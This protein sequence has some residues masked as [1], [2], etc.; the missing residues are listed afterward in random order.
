MMYWLYRTLKWSS[1]IFPLKVNYRLAKMLG[2]LSCALNQ[3]QQKNVLANLSGILPAGTP[4]KERKRVARQIFIN[5]FKYLFDFFSSSNIDSVKLSSLT[6]FPKLKIFES[7]HQRKQAFIIISAHLGNWEIAAAIMDSLGYD[8]NII[9]QPLKNHRLNALFMSSRNFRYAKL[10]PL[11][12]GLRKAFKSLEDGQ[13]LSMVGDWGIGKEEGIEV[14]FF[15]KKTRFP[16]GPAN[17]AIKT[18]VD[19]LP[20]FTIR[21]SP[22]HFTV[23]LE[24]PITYDQSGSDEEKCREIT[25]KFA[26]VLEKYVK[27][28]PDQ[29][30]IFNPLW[31]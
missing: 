5:F 22:N 14:E 8:N 3:Q 18:K 13:P 21:D 25:Q 24:P 31:K 28:Y 30:L 15:S 9:Y 6:S 12:I 29:W 23:F 10:I 27:L 7:Y 19:L 16:T 20:G 1:H 26:N 11:G 2:C 4:S 17:L